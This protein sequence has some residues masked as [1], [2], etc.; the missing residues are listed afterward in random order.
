MFWSEAARE[1]FMG[2]NSS[3]AVVA[4][5]PAGRMSLDAASSPARPKTWRELLAD[6]INRFYG[7]SVKEVY[8]DYSYEY[9]LY[10]DYDSVESTIAA[11]SN[12][13]EGMLG[14]TFYDFSGVDWDNID[15]STID[16]ESFK[17]EY[18][19]DD[20]KKDI[21]RETDVNTCMANGGTN[22]W[23]YDY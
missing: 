8:G 11:A 5:Y 2:P 6:M 12:Y 14:E 13:Y 19:E 17:R 3:A 7:V 15:Y 20:I 23:G 18:T 4:Q 1:Y 21:Q 16:W 9:T 22:C 10:S